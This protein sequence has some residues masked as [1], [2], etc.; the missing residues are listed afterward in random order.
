MKPIKARINRF[1][2]VGGQVGEVGGE[3][4]GCNDHVIPQGLPV[5]AI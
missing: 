5:V 1:I 4:T 2:A 3:D